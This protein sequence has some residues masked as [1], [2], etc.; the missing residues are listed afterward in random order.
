[1]FALRK[2][3][4]GPTALVHDR[5][6]S[7]LFAAHE[8][9]VNGRWVDKPGYLAAGDR[10]TAYTTWQTGWGGGLAT[11]LPLIAAGSKTS[12]D[13]AF[14]T[15]AFALGGGQARSG[16]FHGISD[17]KTWYDDGFVPPVSAAPLP[18]G[19][20]RP[21]PVVYKHARRWHL[22]RRSA[23]TLT[24]LVK[25]LALLERHPELRAGAA[26]ERWVEAARRAADALVKLWE[27]NKQLGQ[28]VDIESGELVVGG[29]TSAGLAPA[30]LALAA[31]QLKQPRYLVTAKAMG[32]HYYDRFV[33]VGLT[34]GGPGD[35]LQAPDSQSAAALLDS[36]MTLFEAT[37][38]RVW[39]DR[40]RATAHL[41]ASWVIS[42]DAPGAG[43]ACVDSRVR[44]TGAVFWSAGSEHGSPGYVLSSGD[45]LLRLYRA[46]G[47][48][49][50]LELLRDTV[51]NLAQ[52]L[53]EAGERPEAPRDGRPAVRAGRSGALVRGSRAAPSRRR[54]CSTPSGCCRTRRCPASTCASTRGFVFV[55][56]HVTARVKERTRGRLVLAVANPTQG[57]RD[58]SHP[59]RR[60]RTAPP[61][62]CARAPCSTRRRRSCRRGRRS[63]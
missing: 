36:F 7:A 22:V 44:A 63:R 37:R 14:A 32:E 62:R 11:T 9:R 5:P 38:D 51:H 47:D 61:S 48:V 41:L 34:C 46:T 33:R 60:R 43:Q 16:F 39:I 30:G 19:A 27:R 29:S 2:E 8:A 55:F 57:G 21:Q 56:D 20:P 1:M 15:T 42:S 17:G 3:L 50:L 24:L 53:P 52:Y 12:R 26:S 13:R 58:G 23:E 45:A 31:A 35:V 28:F 18:P 49:A 4:T 59:R 54:A 6:F 25:Q 10:S 40:A